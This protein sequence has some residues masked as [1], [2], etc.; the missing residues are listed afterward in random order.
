MAC[1][2]CKRNSCSRMFHSLEDQ[3][4]FDNKTGKYSEDDNE[5]NISTSSSK[6]TNV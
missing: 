4:A 6:D 2:I 5:D 1:E 3:E